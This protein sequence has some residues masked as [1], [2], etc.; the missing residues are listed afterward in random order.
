M[1]CLG[2]VEVGSAVIHRSRTFGLRICRETIGTDTGRLLNSD[3]PWPRSED[4][5]RRLPLPPL[6]ATGAG[7]TEVTTPCAGSSAAGTSSALPAGV[8]A[9]SSCPPEPVASRCKSR[10]EVCLGRVEVAGSRGTVPAS[11]SLGTSAPGSRLLP[12]HPA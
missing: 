8:I 3:R 5:A 11:D 7:A 10:E 9:I 1:V 2:R 6:G 4:T 12:Y